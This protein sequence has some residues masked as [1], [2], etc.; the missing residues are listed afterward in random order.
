MAAA[1][2]GVAA[3]AASACAGDEGV[4]V[5]PAFARAEATLS[6]E[7]ISV[8]VADTPDLRRRGLMGV[9]DLGDLDGMLFRF[10]GEVTVAFTMRDTLIPLDIAFFDAAG[11]EVDRLSMVPCRAEPCPTYRAGA[12]FSSALEVPAG[13]LPGPP[14]LLLGGLPGAG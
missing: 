9:T 5:D 6:G 3:F 12:P 11:V 14:P 8:A 13:A 1:F 7:A 4:G 2:L 10:D